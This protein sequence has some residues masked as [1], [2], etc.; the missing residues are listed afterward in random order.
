MVIQ[1]LLIATE[2]LADTMHYIQVSLEDLQRQ[3]ERKVDGSAEFAKEINNMIT[4]LRE[5]GV[6]G[7]RIG[8]IVKALV[9]K[10]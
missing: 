1:C 2:S 7:G 8:D 5:A 6:D 4:N 10:K 3:Q 9:E